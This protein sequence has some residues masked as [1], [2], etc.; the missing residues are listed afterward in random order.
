MAKFSNATSNIKYQKCYSTLE[1]LR[2]EI[3]GV[4]EARDVEIAL[5]KKKTKTVSI[6][7]TAVS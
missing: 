7:L 1:K 4:P 3:L 6:F 5:L 2:E